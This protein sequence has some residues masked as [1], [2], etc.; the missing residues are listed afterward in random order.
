MH[1][2]YVVLTYK[3]YCAEASVIVPSF[4]YKKTNQDENII[5]AAIHDTLTGYYYTGHSHEDAYFNMMQEEEYDDLPAVK[6]FRKYQ[7]T[8]PYKQRFTDGFYTDADRFL[9]RSE[10]LQ[11]MRQ[12][13]KPVAKIDL[14]HGHELHSHVVQDYQKDLN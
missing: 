2:K 12:H 4:L 1:I 10:A 13:G 5:A 7:E 3:Q 6:N 8:T 9:T 11:F 14:K